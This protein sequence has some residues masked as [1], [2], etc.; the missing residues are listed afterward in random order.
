MQHKFPKIL[1][2]GLAPAS[3]PDNPQLEWNPPGHGDIY[4]ALVTS[5]A[6]KGF[7]ERGIRYAFVSNSDNLGATL[8][9]GLLGHFAAEEYPFMMEVA[10]RTPSDQKGGHLA[11]R[12]Q[13]GRL[14]LREIAQCPPEETDAFTDIHRYRYFNT[15]S[16]W[17]NLQHLQR[18]A[19]R[20]G[21][22]DL[23]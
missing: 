3:W 7:L 13:D 23:P 10:E 18:L 19:D 4:T 1:R 22:G 2:D 8:D 9:E 5:G 16:I 17:I 21:I 15:N 12:R 14:V 6:L 11:R 20:G